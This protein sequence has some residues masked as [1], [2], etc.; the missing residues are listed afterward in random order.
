MKLLIVV[1][2]L[3]C[4]FYMY[5]RLIIS[6]SDIKEGFEEDADADA[7]VSG[8]EDA[9]ADLKYEIFKAYRE[10]KGENPSMKRFSEILK[11]LKENDSY[12]LN[13][14]KAELRLENT[15]TGNKLD[16]YQK[17]RDDLDDDDI[18]KIRENN[19]GDKY[20]E[21]IFEKYMTILGHYPPIN[22][23][24]IISKK[25]NTDN[26]EYKLSDLENELKEKKDSRDKNM[27]N[28]VYKEIYGREPTMSEYLDAKKDKFLSRDALKESLLGDKES[29]TATIGSESKSSEVTTTSTSTSTASEGS[30]SSATTTATG[31]YNKEDTTKSYGMDN[32]KQKLYDSA[33][34][35]FSETAIGSLVQN[36]PVDFSTT[37]IHMEG[38]SKPKPKSKSKFMQKPIEY[39]EDDE[40]EEEYN[41]SDMIDTIEESSKRQFCSDNKYWENDTLANAR[42]SR[43]MEDLELQCK[44]G[45]RFLN[46]D[47]NMVLYKEFEWSV[48]QKR[49]PICTPVSGGCDVQ[50]SNEQ[51]SLIGTLLNQAENTQVGSILPK[52]TY[53]EEM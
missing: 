51:T 6:E 42:N 28:D 20:M 40:E 15:K 32:I 3:F 26:S 23:Y 27:I 44:R 14:L 7:D 13:N 43:N 16:K 48:P 36:I 5:Y 47:D 31:T 10:M 45:S 33:K 11:A 9:S 1:F 35:I 12:T 29:T 2:L 41:T 52:F 24:R 18:D 22:E 25:L 19:N 34:S 49:A 53:K 37:K 50:M 17:K 21:D 38:L 46:A 4:G 30:E 8:N 39:E